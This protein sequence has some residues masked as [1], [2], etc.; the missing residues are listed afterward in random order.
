MGKEE[1]MRGG[2]RRDKGNSSREREEG[3]RTGR[4]EEKGEENERKG[5][6]RRKRSPLQIFC[7]TL[8]L[9]IGGGKS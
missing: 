8:S 6:E 1:G 7:L 3:E 5:R 9:L 2:G 4:E